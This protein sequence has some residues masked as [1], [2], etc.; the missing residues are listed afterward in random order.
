MH[1][2]GVTLYESNAFTGEN[3]A[4]MSEQLAHIHGFAACDTGSRFLESNI[5]DTL[6]EYEKEFFHDY[7]VAIYMTT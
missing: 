1:Q 2:P 6:C 7:I 3:T 5:L 4:L